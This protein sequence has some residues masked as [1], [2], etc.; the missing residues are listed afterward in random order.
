M[1]KLPKILAIA[2]WY[3]A[4]AVRWLVDAF[5][6][7]GC[8]VVRCGPAYPNHMDVKW[9]SMPP[10]DMHLNHGSDWNL[11]ALLDACTRYFG[12]P[13][14]IFLSEEDYRNR[15]TPT[16]KLP[17]ILWSIDA[18]WPTNTDRVSM[19]QP[20][21]AYTPQI[22]GNR[23]HPRQEP[24]PRW[25][26]LPS[27]AYPPV[28]KRL[29]MDRDIDFCLY[30]SFY[31]Q[32]ETLCHHLEKSGVRILSGQVNTGRYVVGYNRAIC[33]LNNCGFY[34][35]KYRF[36]EA[37]AMGCV[38]ISDYTSCF[39]WTGYIPHEHYHPIS[40]RPDETGDPWPYAPDLL[41]AVLRL[42]NNPSY[43]KEIANNAYWHT[44]KRH[45][46]YSRVQ[47]ILLDLGMRYEW[48]YVK[49]WIQQKYPEW[50]IS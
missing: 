19:I 26:F 3:S 5:E 4:N 16:A 11:D 44:M 34:E 45:T 38:S 9:E 48:L 46:Y 37:A 1:N 15:I 36:Y 27:A 47:T 14:L 22:M 18:G 41:E 39:A 28:H 23:F 8:Q 43:A 10:I 25:K 31:G 6:D 33:T 30:A 35:I 2:P 20:T 32:R 40:S 42:R 12:A 49:D 21:L 7:I 29:N 24:D 17:T 50:G 13:D